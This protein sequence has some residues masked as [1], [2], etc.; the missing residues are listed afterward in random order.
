M[1]LCLTRGPMRRRLFISPPSSF[2]STWRPMRRWTSNHHTLP[3]N[4]SPTHRLCLLDNNLLL[5][6]QP[7]NRSDIEVDKSS[8]HS[9][10]I[11]LPMYS[12]NPRMGDEFEIKDLK[13]LKYFLGIEV[14]R[15]KRKY[16]P[17]EFNGK[18]GNSDD[19]V[20]I[21]KEQYQ[22]P[23]DTIEAFKAA[24]SIANNPVQHDRTKHVEIDR[25]FIKERLDSGS[26]CI[27]Y[28]PSSQ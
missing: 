10:P 28:I 9:K 27:P 5:T 25:H 12:K 17:N 26:I 19:Q 7:Q 2:H 23:V 16:P 20:S 15:S 3:T 1:L 11:K 14:A 22:C 6:N 18:L 4:R 8:A 13:N 21:D 24:I